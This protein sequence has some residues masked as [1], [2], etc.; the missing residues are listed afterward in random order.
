MAWTHT[1]TAGY[2]TR[3]QRRSTT[4]SSI[5]HSPGRFGS[6]LARCLVRHYSNRHQEQSSSGGKRGDRSGQGA[7]LGALTSSSPSLPRKFGKSEMLGASAEPTL[8]S[9]L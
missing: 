1:T 3:N 7:A 2:A 4:S 8:K 9:K 6:G 5:A